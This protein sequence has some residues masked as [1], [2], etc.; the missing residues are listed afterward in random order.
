MS[1]ILQSVFE[2][3]TRDMEQ[4]EDD[5]TQDNLGK[6]GEM[7]YECSLIADLKA[8]QHTDDEDVGGNG[9]AASSENDLVKILK[10]RY[11]KR[12]IFVSYDVRGDFALKRLVRKCV[13]ELKEIGF[14]DDIWF[15]KDEGQPLSSSSFA[16][17]LEV[18]EECNAVI[19]FVSRDYFLNGPSKYE[20][21][22]FIQR[23]RSNDVKSNDIPFRVFVVKNTTVFH[24]EFEMFPV[25]VDLTTVSVCQES[26]A[27]K[28]SVVVG[29]LSGQ[30]ERCVIFTTKLYRELPMVQGLS[31]HVGYDEKSVNAWDISD[32]QDWLCSLRIHERYRVNFE[33]CEVDG[34]LL[35]SL[36]EE[37]MAEFLAVD[38]K[39]AR[40]KIVQHLKNILEKEKRS[41]WDEYCR[42]RK[43]RDTSVYLVCDPTDAW[44]AE[45]IKADLMRIGI[46]VR[47]H[48]R[49][50]LGRAK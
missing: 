21:N 14:K 6:T 46:M 9:G 39:V 7:K 48:R 11:K 20:A 2:M 37:D 28:A 38:S 15:D 1:K 12:G 45:F 13:E 33:E 27:E 29:T 26:V 32:V 36:E 10:Q 47:Y 35:E 23:A 16:Q 42:S 50:G 49:R 40:Q 5:K 41:C 22:V 4:E 24:E 8:R 19:V 25:H 43:V 31:G 3:V 17:R 44:I 34:F 30:L 18:A